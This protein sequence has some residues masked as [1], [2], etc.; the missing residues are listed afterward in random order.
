MTLELQKAQEA[1]HVAVDELMSRLQKTLGR[2][3]S[4]QEFIAFTGIV[5]ATMM[6][7][8][9]ASSVAS[10]GF[11]RATT[12][13]AG[14]LG[15]A[16]IMARRGGAEILIDGRFKVGPF[17]SLIPTERP[18]AEPVKEE[19]KNCICLGVI[20]PECCVSCREAL[21]R[22]IDGY[23]DIFKRFSGLLENNRIP[24]KVCRDSAVDKAVADGL[25]RHIKSFGLSAPIVFETFVSMVFPRLRELSE[26]DWTETRKALLEIK[27]SIE[28]IARP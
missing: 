25:K 28:K 21:D 6:G 23:A 7:M 11:E 1:A 17:P 15:M 22:K 18:S 26:A 27:G 2:S 5:A 24:C 12:W 9:L 16:Q 8:G 20:L 19:P 4:P 3:A 14:L 10:V 13:L